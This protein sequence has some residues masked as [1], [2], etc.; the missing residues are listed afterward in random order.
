MVTLFRLF[1]VFIFR[2]V[3][4]VQLDVMRWTILKS[5]WN[6]ANWVSLFVMKNHTMNN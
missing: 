3:H 6:C 2:E 1:N 4:L 5:R